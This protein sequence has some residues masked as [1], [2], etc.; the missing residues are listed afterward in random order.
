MALSLQRSVVPY[1]HKTSK[2]LTPASLTQLQKQVLVLPASRLR[3]VLAPCISEA[4]VTLYG[5]AIK[6]TEQV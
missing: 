6:G 3:F 1:S 5:L 2:N 4:K